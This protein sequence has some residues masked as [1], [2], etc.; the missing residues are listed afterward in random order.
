MTTNSIYVVRVISLRRLTAAQV[1]MCESLRR[2]AGQCWSDMVMAHRASRERSTWLS[3]NDLQ[4]QFA[5]RYSLHSQTVQALAQKL[6]ANIQ[7]A[8][9]SRKQEAA[10]GEIHT[11]YPYKMPEYQT[12][13]WKET[14]IRRRTGLII[15]SNGR[16]RD[17]LILPLPTEYEQSDICKVEL[18]WRADHYELCLSIDTDTPNP[19]LLPETKTAG[20]DLG[21][22]NIAAIV[23]EEGQGLIISGRR[24]RWA[25]QLRNKRHAAYAKR[26]EGC[27][28]GSRRWKRLMRRR[29]QA[30]SKLRRQQRD[31]LHQAS[32]K[33]IA[34]C[35]Q[36]EV[37]RISIG[38]VRSIADGVDLGRRA[39]Q[40]IA[41]WTH[42]QFVD[43]VTYKA[44]RQGIGIDQISEDY[45]SRTCSV[46]GYL[47]LSASR[48]RRFACSGCGA[49]LHRDG[50]GGANICSR[51]RFGIYGKVQIV[52]IMH[53]RAIAVAPRHR[54]K[55]LVQTRTPAL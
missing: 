50:N 32:K 11:K 29:A 2:E 49:V 54:P 28:K 20:L 24:L 13:I 44:R 12:V 45:S 36:Q 30:S 6:A 19:P 48:G 7:T 34:F 9:T 23:T 22:I 53:R 18:T 43:Y 1:E 37:S 14:A 47:H 15:L 42:G 4:K 38:D 39:N 41:Q 25:K 3:E 21:E 27:Q 26:M 40:K 52:Q 35:Q 33:T 51:A 55:L 46:C 16:G 10:T 5:R 31:I 8:T 17:S